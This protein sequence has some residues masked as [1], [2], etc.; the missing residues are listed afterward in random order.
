M[1]L[2]K[3][4]FKSKIDLDTFRQYFIFDNFGDK[5]FIE[6]LLN[7]D[8]AKSISGTTEYDRYY[9]RFFNS[10]NII[11]YYDING[12]KTN[13][14]KDNTYD[15]DL[16]LIASQNAIKYMAYLDLLSGFNNNLG[17]IINSTSAHNSGNGIID[18]TLLKNHEFSI[19]INYIKR[20]GSLFN[21]QNILDACNDISLKFK[22]NTINLDF[23]EKK[24]I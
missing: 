15:L 14:I 20:D 18:D 4:T 9:M 8:L 3:I 2:D 19:P 24:N 16:S 10:R 11:Y 21:N 1:V 5:D 6:L 12:T 22:L 7:E 13:G 17:I 23:T